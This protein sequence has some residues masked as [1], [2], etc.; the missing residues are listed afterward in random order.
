MSGISRAEYQAAMRKEEAYRAT[1]AP[2]VRVKLMILYASM[3][4]MFFNASTGEIT[5]EY[6]AQ[7]TAMLAECDRQIAEIAESFTEDKP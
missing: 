1:I 3:P 4:K 7:T 2:F 6:D 5:R